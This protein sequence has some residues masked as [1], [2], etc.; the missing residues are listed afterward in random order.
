MRF[1]RRGGFGNSNSL[2]GAAF[3]TFAGQ[4]VGGRESPGATCEHANSQADG[5]GL[6]ESADFPV[7]GGEVALALVH[8]ADVGV[9]GAT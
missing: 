1:A 9:S 6:R 8:H 5:F 3:Y 7:F 2:S 4:P